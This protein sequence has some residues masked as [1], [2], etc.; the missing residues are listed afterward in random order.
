MTRQF[1]FWFYLALC[2]LLPGLLHAQSASSGIE[3]LHQVLEDTRTQMQTM[4]ADLVT[5]AQ[6]LAGFGTLF[7]IGSRV[8]KHIARGEG[9]DMYPLLKPLAILLCIGIFP[10]VLDV[11]NSIMKPTVTA[12]AALAQHAN[13]HVHN[14]L[15]AQAAM[16]G[17]GATY[18]ALIVPMPAMTSEDNKYTQ[19]DNTDSGGGGIWSAIGQGF[20][21]IASGWISTLRYCFR[22][23][24]SILLE[25]LYYAA[26][27]CID[28]IR[29]FHLIVLG[30]LGPFAF[31]FSCYDGFQN[32]LTHWL[33]R[34]INIYLW[35]PICN[36]FGAIM[37]TIQANML[38][39]DL[40][41]IDSG[42]L[43]IFSPT[44]IAY[45]IFLVMG[46]V[47][48]FTVPSIANYIIHTHGPNPI[49]G[50]MSSMTGA[51]VNTA[52]MAGTG[53]PGGAGGMGAGGLAG[54]SGAA[55]GG[56]ASA[57]GG[58]AAGG[59]AD[60]YNRDKISGNSSS[61]A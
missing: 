42:S 17:G 4:C 20:K 9:V 14:L 54:G 60:Q 45:L 25:I 49:A 7:Y 57:A 50:R 2:C 15:T 41:R 19:P 11:I 38:Q 55:G 18:P 23:M 10:K 39:L 43:T 21:F 13:D 22:L 48:Y 29:T 30:V 46:V 52:I 28:T 16:L 34:Y 47:G 56:G 51:V 1:R 8:W 5:L 3:T 32:S 12:T 26:A 31:A 27:L 40:S 59:A 24:L 33:A 6:A 61:N 58:F 44:D 53:M 35:L 36:L 37:S